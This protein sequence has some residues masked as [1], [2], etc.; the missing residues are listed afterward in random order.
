MPYYEVPQGLHELTHDEAP[1]ALHDMTQA[2][3]YTT[4]GADESKRQ[5]KSSRTMMMYD[6]Q[7]TSEC[8]YMTRYM[9]HEAPA[10]L[11]IRIG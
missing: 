9:K 8:Q 5:R 11:L 3:T 10:A 4:C 2:S 1:A 7:D 6:V